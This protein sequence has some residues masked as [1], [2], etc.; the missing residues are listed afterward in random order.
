MVPYSCDNGYVK[1]GRDGGRYSRMGVPEGVQGPDCADFPGGLAAA[2]V[3]WDYNG[4]EI[5]L[6]FKAGFVGAEQDG[7]TGVVRPTIGWFISH[8]GGSHAKG[9]GKGGGEKGQ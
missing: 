3:I 8:D 7:V 5:K 9:E 6:K 4:T 1:E 2:P